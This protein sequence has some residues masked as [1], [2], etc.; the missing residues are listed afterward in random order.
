MIMQGSLIKF[1][2]IEK[3]FYINKT[4]VKDL[5]DRLLIWVNKFF[6]YYSFQFTYFTFG[7]K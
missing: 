2:L 6:N 7:T 4:I 3:K 1:M 5:F